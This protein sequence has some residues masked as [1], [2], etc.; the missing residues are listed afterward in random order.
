[1]TT[2]VIFS[3]PFSSIPQVLLGAMRI[4]VNFIAGLNFL[5]EI[6]SITTIGFTA[7][8]SCTSFC[9][10]NYHL[11]YKYIAILNPDNFIKSGKITL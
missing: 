3:R 10:P 4:N 11:V 1:M 6:N 2:S 7:S 8:V 5:V 9:W